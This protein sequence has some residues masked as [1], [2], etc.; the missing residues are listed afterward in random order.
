MQVYDVWMLQNDRVMPNNYV[1]SHLLSVLANAG[2]TKKAFQ[3]FNQVKLY[4]V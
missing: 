3:V 1:I 2:Y 4:V